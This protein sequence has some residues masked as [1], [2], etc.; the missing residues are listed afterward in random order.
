MFLINGSPNVSDDLTGISAD[1]TIVEG[2]ID[3]ID[4]ETDKIAAI[5]TKTDEL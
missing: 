2:K 1:I 4:T 3:I 5:K